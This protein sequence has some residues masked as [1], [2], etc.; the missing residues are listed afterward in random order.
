MDA[1]SVWTVLQTVMGQAAEKTSGITGADLKSV[2]AF[3]AA[4]MCMLAVAGAGLGMG[5]AAGKASEGVARNPQAAGAVMRVMLVGQAV[6]ES[7]AIYALVVALL[8]LF[9]MI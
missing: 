9:V 1:G 6:A 2:A 8:L 5:N 7:T 4:G 3:I